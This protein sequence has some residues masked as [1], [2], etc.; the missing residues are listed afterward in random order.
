MQTIALIPPPPK[1]WQPPIFC[2]D[3][4]SEIKGE[5]SLEE[6]GVI[7]ADVSSMSTKVA[8]HQRGAMYLQR[9]QFDAWGAI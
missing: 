3:C 2:R 9:R 5:H 1:H 6:C 4:A 7:R 8:D